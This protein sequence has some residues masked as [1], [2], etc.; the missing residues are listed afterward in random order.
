M[1]RASTC[2]QGVV[3]IVA[4]AFLAAHAHAQAAPAGADCVQFPCG[5]VLSIVQVTVKEDWTPLGTTTG[6]MSP[7]N[8][9]GQVATVVEFGPGMT[10]RGVV[11]L[12][13]SGGAVYR[14]S[15]NAY[16]KPQWQVTVQLD[17]GRTRVL[18]VACE[19]YVREGDRVRVAGNHVELLD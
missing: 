5:R 14:K 7:G 17:T 15:P 12:G 11:V 9:P 4:A 13:A 1:A 3:A 19:P 10:N 18:T 6:A 16:E 8:R 2:L